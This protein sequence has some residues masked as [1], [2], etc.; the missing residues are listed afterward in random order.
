MATSFALSSQPSLP[1]FQPISLS[2]II[3]DKTPMVNGTANTAKTFRSPSFHTPII[4]NPPI[5]TPPF[6]NN[7]FPSIPNITPYLHRSLIKLPHSHHFPLPKPKN[8]KNTRPETARPAGFLTFR[9]PPH[10]FRKYDKIPSP[11][12]PRLPCPFLININ[13]LPLPSWKN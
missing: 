8:K 2:D 9:A 6:H 13:P 5:I 12:L 10:F 4:P 3:H 1:T 11:S 7:N